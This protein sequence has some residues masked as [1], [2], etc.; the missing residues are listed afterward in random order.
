MAADEILDG[1]LD[2]LAAIEHDRWAHWQRYVHDKS[3]KQSD[4]SLLIP[5]ELV[6]RWEKQIETP[7]AL[8]SDK[9]KDSDRK[10]VQKYL[11]LLKAA[12][13]E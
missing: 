7:F 13:R 2:E 11:P 3:Q 9:E 4:G 8:L 12:L 5:A 1:L 10:Q 6:A